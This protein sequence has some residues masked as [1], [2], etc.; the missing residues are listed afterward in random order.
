[1]S[2]AILTAELIAQHESPGGAAHL[3]ILAAVAVTAVMVFGVSRWRRKRARA[4]Q[5][6][7]A[8]DRSDEG[9]RSK[10]PK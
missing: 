2:G 5:H 9:R 7:A 3:V 6:P 4:E 1:V 8:H 10:E